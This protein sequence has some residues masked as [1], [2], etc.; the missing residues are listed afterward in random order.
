MTPVGKPGIPDFGIPVLTYH[1]NNVNN[2]TYQGNDHIALREDLRA[3]HQS[4]WRAISLDALLDWHKGVET[5]TDF[6]GSYAVTFDDGSDFDVHDLEHPVWGQQRSLLNV[7]RDHFDECGEVVQAASFVIASPNAR[8]QLDHH[9]LVGR[10]WWNDDWWSNANETGFLT[11]ESHGW[12]HLHPVLDEVA[13]VDGLAGD[14]TRVDTLGDC[15]RQLQ[16]SGRTIEHLSGRRPRYFAFPWGQFSDYLVSRYL[17]DHQQDHRYHAA[18]ST[19]PSAVYH[20]D[21]RWCLPRYVCG[22]DWGS[23]DALLELMRASAGPACP[24]QRPG[25]QSLGGGS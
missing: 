13:Q 6:R 17:P 3:L 5:V 19:R 8:Q 4:G 10:N 11:I 21:N 23:P 25:D 24:A 14:F 15:E 20:S 2:N 22:D 18:F 9:C 12:D 16:H 7:L 1:A